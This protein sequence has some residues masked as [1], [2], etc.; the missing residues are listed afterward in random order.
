MDL[1]GLQWAGPAEA[2]LQCEVA[3]QE[4]QAMIEL[5]CSDELGSHDFVSCGGILQMLW[6]MTIPDLFRLRTVNYWQA[7]RLLLIAGLLFGSG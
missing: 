4:K 1:C 2:L 3:G 7:F 5:S 6:S